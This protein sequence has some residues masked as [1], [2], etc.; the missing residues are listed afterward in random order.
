MSDQC[1]EQ[2][3]LEYRERTWC[4]DDFDDLPADVRMADESGVIEPLLATTAS[5]FLTLHFK[6]TFF[7]TNTR[8]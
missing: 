7:A 1:F 2:A 8:A 3:F 5:G 6:K 4:P